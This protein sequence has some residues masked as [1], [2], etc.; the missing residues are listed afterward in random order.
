[1]QTT[2]RNTETAAD[3]ISMFVC[4]LRLE[5]EGFRFSGMAGFESQRHISTTTITAILVLLVR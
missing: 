4:V 1:M 3:L 5:K 2:C